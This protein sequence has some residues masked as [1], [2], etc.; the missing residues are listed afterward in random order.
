MVVVVLVSAG[1][2]EAGPKEKVD[3]AGAAVAVDDAVVP[4][5]VDPADAPKLKLGVMEGPEGF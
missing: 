5:T 4:A 3:G 1:F 2:D